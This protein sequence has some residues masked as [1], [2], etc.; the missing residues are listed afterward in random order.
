MYKFSY[1]RTLLFTNTVYFHIPVNFRIL[2]FVRILLYENFYSTK[3]SRITV[4]LKLCTSD[5]ITHSLL[6][7]SGSSG[8]GERW[9]INFHIFTIRTFEALEN[10]FVHL[11]IILNSYYCMFGCWKL[12]NYPS[13]YNQYYSF[14]CQCFHWME[15]KQANSHQN[16]FWISPTIRTICSCAQ[17]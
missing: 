1:V 15:Q 5:Y 8:F 12:P 2:N 10:T 16:V 13:A 11:I 9:S 3:F 17:D 7:I 4:P 14:S 6:F